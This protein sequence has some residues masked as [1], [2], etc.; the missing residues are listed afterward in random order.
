MGQLLGKKR[1]PQAACIE[2]ANAT[3]PGTVEDAIAYLQ[4]RTAPHVVAEIQRTPLEELI[5][6][7]RDLGMQIR[8]SLGLW[9]RNPALINCLPEAERWP[10]DAAM[11]LLRAWWRS[12]NPSARSEAD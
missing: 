11:Y 6:F 7:H 9:G 1:K 4:S 12:L 8:N 3:L 10:D 2:S 5:D